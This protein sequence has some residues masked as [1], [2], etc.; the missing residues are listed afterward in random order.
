MAGVPESKVEAPV[1]AREGRSRRW[2][3]GLLALALLVR[4]LFLGRAELWADEVLFVNAANLPQDPIEVFGTL[5]KRF[6]AIGHLPFSYM[7]QNAFLWVAQWFATDVA[8]H[9]FLQRFPSALWGA[10][11]VPVFVQVGRRLASE[12][13]A[14]V[15]S[16]FLAV[17][18][19]PVYYSREAYVYAPLMFLSVAMLL[20]VLNVAE[21]GTLTKRQ[22][23]LLLA[24]GLAI[25]LTHLTGVL[26]PVTILGLALGCLL[27]NRY[28]SRGVPD[29]LKRTYL[30][31]VGLMGVAALSAVPFF[32][33]RLAQP[34]AHQ[35]PQTPSVVGTLRHL[36]GKICLGTSAA[37][38]IIAWLLLAAGVAACVRRGPRRTMRLVFLA[39]T[40]GI[41]GV[42]LF[43]TLRTQYFSRYFWCMIPNLYILFAM[44]LGFYAEQVTRLTRAA[45]AGADFWLTA[46]G[47]ALAAA[48]LGIFLPP[49]YRL[50]A[51]SL[52]YGQIARWLTQNLPPNAPYVFESGY[53]YRF[54]PGFFPTPGHPHAVPYVHGPGREEMMKLRSLQERFFLQFPLSCYVEASRHGAEPE[55]DYDVWDWPHKFFR[56]TVELKNEPLARMISL[57]IHPGPDTALS[58]LKETSTP[59]W[60]NAAEDVEAMARA[61]GA[62]LHVIYDEWQCAQVGNGVYM[63]AAQGPRALIRVKNL[64]GV[65]VKGKFMIAGGLAGADKSF[66][67]TFMLGDQLLDRSTRWAGIMWTAETAEVTVPPG[68]QYLLYALDG[69]KPEELQALLLQGIHFR[70]SR[71]DAPAAPVQIPFAPEVAPAPPASAAP[72][73]D[74]VP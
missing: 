23:V 10:F 55:T 12:R 64:R 54:V 51:K 71:A 72:L 5:Y 26:V 37:G 4:M 9:P 3:W 2:V 19:F 62:P 50:T 74:A 59:I 25:S 41:F 69:A 14:L 34:S 52:D 60:W 73:L 46:G 70:E 42:I 47:L 8:H 22:A 57:G 35:W 24:T 7:V 32:A 43:S 6:L 28:P 1:D 16:L 33:Q 45:R 17:F 13:L 18:F 65:P 29:M 40:T 49:L 66:E 56:R 27:V 30:K 63:Y 11:T 36:V 31:L 48:H 67:V 21:T 58:A 15:A 20:L 53:D 61:A 38:E 44:G 68:E 39:L